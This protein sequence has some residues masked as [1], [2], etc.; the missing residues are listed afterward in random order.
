VRSTNIRCAQSAE[1]VELAILGDITPYTAEDIMRAVSFFK[2]QPITITMMSGGGD[3]FASLGLY[4]F[5]KG[6]DVTVRIY[7]IAASGAAII[8]AAAKRVE[9][10]AS[11]FL[12]IHEAYAVTGEQQDVTDSINE[13]QVALFAARSGKSKDK[14]RKMLQAETFMDAPTAKAEGF[15]DAVFDPLKVAAS[16]TNMQPM[17][18]VIKEEAAPIIDDAAEVDAPAQVEAPAEPVAEVPAADPGDEQPEPEEVE[19]EIPVTTGEAIKAAIAGKFKARVKVE[20]RAGEVLASLIAENKNLRAQLDEANAQVE[21]LAPA[22]E[23]AA[24][25]KAA[26]E[27]AEAKAAEVT[28]EV[29]KLKTQP[30]APPV[31]ADAAP[32]AVV[33]AQQERPLSREQQKMKQREQ[34][35]AEA[36]ARFAKKPNA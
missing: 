33:P 3:A 9:M 22:A 35:M 16:L 10:A 31:V 14:V 23:A 12:M 20:G 11:S 4:D 24:A 6:K 2:D 27:A 13:R 34:E 8:S 29:E 32:A 5:L 26:A 1:G 19:V 18:Q 17:E 28:A 21:Q 30:L 25:A 36:Y 7:G 15:A